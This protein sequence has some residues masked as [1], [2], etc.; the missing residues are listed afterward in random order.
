MTRF[1]WGAWLLAV[2]SCTSGYDQIPEEKMIDIIVDM[3]LS[4]QIIRKYDPVDRDSMREELSKTLLKV[5]NV[6]Q[7]QLDT[8]LYIYQYDLTSYRDMTIK[9][10]QKLDSLQA[11]IEKRTEQQ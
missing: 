3:H 2:V 7:E 10:V 8:N 4:D 5:H 11:K 1:V 6:T 9:V